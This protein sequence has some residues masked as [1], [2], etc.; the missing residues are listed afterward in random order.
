MDIEMLY[1]EHHYSMYRYAYSLLN[2]KSDAEDIV[3]DIFFKLIINPSNLNK[4]TNVCRYLHWLVKVRVG[5]KMR[6]KE[7]VE[8]TMDIADEQIELYEIQGAVLDKLRQEINHL[9]KKSRDVF[10]LAYVYGFTNEI[11]SR[12]TGISNQSVRTSKARSMSK[13]RMAIV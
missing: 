8:L 6:R 11:I 10:K 7:S 9:P 13:I 3:A 2:H 5:D 4:T 12:I 1:K